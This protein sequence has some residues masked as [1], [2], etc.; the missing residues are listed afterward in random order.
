[1]GQR[2]ALFSS[3]SSLM[4]TDRPAG[5]TLQALHYSRD[6]IISFMSKWVSGAES[7]PE[8]FLL[9]IISRVYIYRDDALARARAEIKKQLRRCV[10]KLLAHVSS[11]RPIW[12]H[13]SKGISLPLTLQAKSDREWFARSNRNWEF[14][15]ADFYHT[16]Q[17]KQELDF[18]KTDLDF[19][20]I[21]GR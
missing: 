7:R 13:W 11:L 17:K 21:I 1:M 20:F 5:R 4:P 18:S 14:S 3:L 9:Y 15:G 12:S 8:T 10:Q 16:T 6:R 2:D 19:C